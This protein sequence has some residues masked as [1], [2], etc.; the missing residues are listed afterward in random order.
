MGWD[1]FSRDGV[2]GF[3]GDKPV[4][5]LAEALRRVSEDYLDRFARKPT[6][7]EVL[8]GLERALSAQP[9][10]FVSDHEGVVGARIAMA[11]PG[12]RAVT[13][14][15]P[16]AY[17][18]SYSPDD[19]GFYAIE[20]RSSGQ[21]VAHVPQIDVV[22]D[23]LGVDFRI[24]GPNISDE[25]VHHLVITLILEGLSQGAY[26]KEVERICFKNLDTGRSESVE[27]S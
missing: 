24:V 6:V 2:S 14:P 20:L 13:L 15:D 18:A 21:D 4:D 1:E 25:G 16:A 11:R 23:T 27:Y 5:R 17:E 22:G 8:Y 19:G 9:A 7:T 10:R 12:A 26:R 3:T